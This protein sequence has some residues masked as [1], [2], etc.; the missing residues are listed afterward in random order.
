MFNE[1]KK[2]QF[3]LFEVKIPAPAGTGSPVGQQEIQHLF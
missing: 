3:S 2:R 1:G